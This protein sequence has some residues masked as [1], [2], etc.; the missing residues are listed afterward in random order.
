MPRRY[1]KKHFGACKYHSVTEHQRNPVCLCA[2]RPLSDLD[3]EIMAD[4]R[5]RYSWD[6]IAEMLNRDV[7]YLLRQVGE[8]REAI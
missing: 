3:V 1:Q 8:L 5:K 4:M 2:K 6:Q 7:D